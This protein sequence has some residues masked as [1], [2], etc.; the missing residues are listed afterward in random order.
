MRYWLLASAW[1]VGLLLFGTWFFWRAE[2]RYG[3]VD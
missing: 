2:E 1:S 3:R